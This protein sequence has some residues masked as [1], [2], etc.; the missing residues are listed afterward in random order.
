M[1]RRAKAVG[2]VGLQNGAWV[3]PGSDD[4]VEFFRTLAAFVR[5]HNGAA[6]ALSVR[7]VEDT[8]DDEIV[9]RFRS[10]RSKEFAELNERGVA[11]LSELDRE[12]SKG[13]FSFAELEENEQV[14]E[15][16]AGWLDKIVARDFFPDERTKDAAELLDRCR[17]AV[18]GFTASVYRAEG[19]APELPPTTETGER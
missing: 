18:E 16:L 9:A 5:D 2:A 13:N 8:G 7:T 4:N 12:A 14:L 15:R 19:V 17:R 11:L 6:H 3:L 10:E 1:W